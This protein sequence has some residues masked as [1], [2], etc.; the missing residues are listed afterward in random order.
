M[1]WNDFEILNIERDPGFQSGSLQGYVS[2]NYYNLVDVFGEPTH[3]ESGDSKVFNEWELEFTVQEE[4]EEDSERVF[5]T[6]YDWK[7]GS[8]MAA[9]EET[10]YNWHI[11]GKDKKSVEV[12]EKAIKDH[13]AGK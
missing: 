12:V 4:G 10:K 5:A 9:R 6:I 13:F 3:G 7:T 2:E 11:G 8:Q 1:F